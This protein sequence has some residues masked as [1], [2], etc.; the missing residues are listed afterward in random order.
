M[1]AS[2][3]LEAV[4]DYNWKCYLHIIDNAKSDIEPLTSKRLETLV[5]RIEDW[6]DLYGKEHEI[7]LVL[8]LLD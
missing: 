3:E 8:D 2:I 1:A 6:K 5:R 7:A 4:P